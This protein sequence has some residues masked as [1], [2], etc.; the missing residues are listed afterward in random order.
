LPVPVE[1][2]TSWKS[3]LTTEYVPTVELC[4]ARFRSPIQQEG[5]ITRTLDAPTLN[6]SNP[7]V[8]TR[9]H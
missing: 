6:R 4:N 7:G 9:A 5:H 3:V 1:K 8:R 2:V